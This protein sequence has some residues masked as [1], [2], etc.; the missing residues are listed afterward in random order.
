MKILYG[1]FSGIGDLANASL[2]A[3]LID[4]RHQVTLAYN[5]KFDDLLSLFNLSEIDFCRFNDN[6]IQNFF[7]NSAFLI[8]ILLRKY[9]VIII[10]PHCIHN[11]SSSL[12]I[13]FIIRLFKSKNTKIIGHINDRVS[14]YFDVKINSDYGVGLLER[15]INM[16]DQAKL[17]GNNKINS[18]GLF[19]IKPNSVKA[20]KI[21]IHPFAGLSNRVL[22]FWFYIIILQIVTFKSDYTVTFIGKK[23]EL[24]ALKIKII[25]YIDKDKVFFEHGSL[26][27]SIKL[28]CN[29]HLVVA[30]DSGFSHLASLLKLN[31]LLINGASNS[32]LIMPYGSK[33]TIYEKNTMSCQPCN[34]S[35]CIHDTNFCLA[36]LSPFD[37]AESII[38]RVKSF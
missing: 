37:I 27:N 36:N 15:E 31:L 12:I 17:L 30:M 21:I 11:N 38:S 13:P 23:Q 26:E 19:K 25:P 8:H 35:R 6:K 22:P 5:S 10:S 4:K 3:K 28:I 20:K 14:K 7:S 24:L 16:L 18:L 1:F 2:A 34:S 33:V 29:S 32:S 9:D